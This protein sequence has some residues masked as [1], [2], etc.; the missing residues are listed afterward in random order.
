MI[1][2]IVLVLILLIS[3]YMGYKR[4]F[5]RTLASFIG[6]FIAMTLAYFY[7]KPF[8]KLLTELTGMDGYVLEKV[9]RSLVA[10]G[11]HAAESSVAGSDIDALGK[12]P[13]PD[14]LKDKM[15]DYLKQ[16]A[17]SLGNSVAQTISDFVMSL[18][19]F[20]LLF[21]LIAIAI[22]ILVRVLNLVAKLPVLNAF[23][24]VGGVLFS[25]ITTYIILT[26][27]FLLVTSFVSMDAN[28]KLSAM[29]AGSKLAKHFIAY[30]P[31]LLGLANMSL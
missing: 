13:L 24:R 9:K 15:A 28:S 11:G 3:A 25:L 29:I 8:Q 12:M 18:L 22:S 20:F 30:N 5:I 14:V 7:Y 16:S 19:A 1:L 2:D 31:I 21:L 26:I 10:L 6:K 27:L 17:N 23:N 4:G